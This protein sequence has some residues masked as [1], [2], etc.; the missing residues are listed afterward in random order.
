NERLTRQ[1]SPAHGDERAEPHSHLVGV[2]V[3]APQPSDRTSRRA[4]DGPTSDNHTDHLPSPRKTRRFG[5]RR[6]S[7]NFCSITVAAGP[8]LRSRSAITARQAREGRT[9]SQRKNLAAI[10]VA[11][12]STPKRTIRA[13]QLPS[14]VSPDHNPSSSVTNWVS[15]ENWATWRTWSGIAASGKAAPDSMING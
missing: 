3:R 12:P 7:T 4:S 10:V 5:R 1:R 15:G 14:H 13:T 8:P 11:T 6:N 2:P 9:Y